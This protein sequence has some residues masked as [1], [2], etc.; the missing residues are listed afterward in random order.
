MVA[1]Q[2]VTLLVTV[3]ALALAALWKSRSLQRPRKN[4]E[5][6]GIRRGSCQD[7]AAAAGPLVFVDHLKEQ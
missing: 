4:E 7:R 2:L 3:V 5:T 6:Y 1:E